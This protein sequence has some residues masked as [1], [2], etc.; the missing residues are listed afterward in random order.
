MIAIHPFFIFS[1][2]VSGVIIPFRQNLAW[3]SAFFLIFVQDLPCTGVL[4]SAM[5]RIV[6]LTICALACL[7]AACSKAAA[8]KEAANAAPE[9]HGS[10]ADAADAAEAAPAEYTAIVTVKQEGGAVFFQLDDVTTLFPENY[11][12]PFDRQCRI[13]CGLT[14]WEGSG[15]CRVNWLDFLEEGPVQDQPMDAGD[16]VDILDD[17]M[18]SVEDGYLTVHYETLWGNS[19]VPHSLCVVTGENP[20]DPYELRLVHLR[21]A[22]PAENRADALIYFDLNTLPSTGGSYIPL[23]LKWKDGAG[24]AASKIFPF[25]SR[26]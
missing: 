1:G 5:K 18:T 8:P 16:G 2:F 10:Y 15:R 17:W 12:A 23:T 14:L 20:E 25:R 24:N 13:I 21:G 7:L 3:L 6:L 4:A 22:D 26:P 11:T 19:S 9:P